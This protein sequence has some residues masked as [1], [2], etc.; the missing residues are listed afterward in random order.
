MNPH[1]FALL[2]AGI[3]TSLETYSN[4]HR[5]SGVFAR[6]S[7]HLLEQSR[8][9]LLEYLECGATTH[10]A[11]F[12]APRRAENLKSRLSAGSWKEVTSAELGLPLGIVGLAVQKTALPAGLPPETGGGTARLMGPD[13]VVWNRNADRFEAGT[14]PLVAVFTLV[15]ALRLA[16]QYGKD[17]FQPSLTAGASVD[18]IL[19]RDAFEAFH[20]A[21]LLEHLRTTRIGREVKVPTVK[22]MQPFIYLDNAASHPTFEP[23]WDAVRLT[24]QASASV[25]QEVTA[26]VRNDLLRFLGAPPESFDAV[27]TTNA[28]EAVNLAAASIDREFGRN[29]DTVILNTLM[30]HSSNELPWR[31][32]PGTDLVRLT[33]SEQ[34]FIDM[35]LLEDTLRAYNGE[36][37]HGTK[38]IRLVAVSGGSNVL[39]TYNDLEAISRVVHAYGARLLV[40]AAQLVAHRPV[41]MAAW[42]I[43]YLVFSAH[44]AYAPFGTG[45]LVHRNGLL[46]FTPEQTARIRQSGEENA[47]GIAALGKALVLLERIGLNVVAAEETRHTAQLIDGLSAV[48]GIRIFGIRDTHSAAFANRGGVVAFSLGSRLSEQVAEDLSRRAGIGIRWGCH[49][50]HLLVKHLLHVHGFLA[51]FQRL[52]VLVFRKIRLPGVARVSLGMENTDAEID[53][54]LETLADM[55]QGKKADGAT[56]TAQ[57]VK[58]QTDWFIAQ[59]AQRVFEV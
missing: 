57:E 45:A 35:A 33:V 10:E 29:G 36:H 34:G 39:G 48:P 31:T 44:K 26:A 51:G 1:P 56:F 40:D 54:L 20:G 23:V 4:V 19:Y 17:C 28:T 7:E 42:N 53:L 52:L 47:A 41:H 15:R 46:S 18:D 9:L 37:R 11:L 16:T 8:H 25:R 13:W 3:R 30:E 12:C 14:P 27:F 58:D 55:A 2:E 6:V 21:D 59:A 5:G 43:D 22:G 49:C 50:A 32:L 38:R 24:W